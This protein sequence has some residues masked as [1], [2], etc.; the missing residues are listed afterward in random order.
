MGQAVASLQRLLVCRSSILHRACTRP[1]GACWELWALPPVE[2]GGNPLPILYECNPV[3][4]SQ[5]FSSQGS[6]VFPPSYTRL[7]LC[8]CGH[9]PCRSESWVVLWLELAETTAQQEGLLL[10]FPPCLCFRI[11]WH[12]IFQLTILTAI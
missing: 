5:T 10:P 9:L 7:F 12:G 2:L 6:F 4:M 11:I 8:L 3:L 1:A